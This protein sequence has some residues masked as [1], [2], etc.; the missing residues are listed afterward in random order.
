MHCSTCHDP[1]NDQYGQFLVRD[2]RYSALCIRCHEIPGWSGSQHQTSGESTVGILPRP[3][4]TESTW[5]TVAEW[6]CETCHSP[7]FAATPPQLLNFTAGPPEPFSCTSAG[8]HSAEPGPPHAVTPGVPRSHLLALDAGKGRADIAGQVKKASA[9]HETP[10]VFSTSRRN[11]REA[12]RSGDPRRR[13]R[14]LPQRALGG[15]TSTGEAPYASGLLRDVNGVNRQGIEVERAQFEYEICFKCHADN[16]GDFE[17]VPR[18]V[19]STNTR[20]DFD[21]A[22]SSSHP[23]V[24]SGRGGGPSLRGGAGLSVN[25]SIYCSSCHADDNDVS[26]G[27]HGSDFAPILRRRYDLEG[28]AESFEAYNLCYDCHDRGSILANES[29]RTK[30]ARTTASGGGHSGHLAAGASCAACHD[31]HGIP[32]RGLAALADSGSHTSLINFDTRTVQPLD[33]LSGAALRE[34]GRGHG[35]LHADV[36]RRAARPPVLPL[37]HPRSARPRQGRGRCVRSTD[38]AP[39]AAQSKGKRPSV[40][41]GCPPGGGGPSR[42]RTGRSAAPHRSRGARGRAIERLLLKGMAPGPER[43]GQVSAALPPPRPCFV[44]QPGSPNRPECARTTRPLLWSFFSSPAR[45]AGP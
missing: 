37:T 32:D 33:G 6:G 1:H 2:N 13:L 36:P 8:C 29:F 5:T 41:R 35:Q 4:R 42:L 45:A 16:A 39:A 3:P 11:A 18:V 20:L 28:G 40:E 19:S 7:H 23:V 22:N 38:L 12:A 30:G 31:P 26:D 24:G 34:P 14:R 25:G 43:G 9:H 27:P 44:R 21:P 17:R 10:G 15:A